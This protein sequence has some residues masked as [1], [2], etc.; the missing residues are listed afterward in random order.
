VA[1]R[2]TWAQATRTG[3]ILDVRLPLLPGHPGLV[4]NLPLADWVTVISVISDYGREG[5]PPSKVGTDRPLLRATSSALGVKPVDV[6]LLEQ[7]QLF[8]TQSAP[9]SCARELRSGRSS[10][11]RFALPHPTKRQRSS[12][13]PPLRVQCS[14]DCIPMSRGHALAVKKRPYNH[15]S[16]S[17]TRFLSCESWR[18]GLQKLTRLLFPLPQVSSSLPAPHGWQGEALLLTCTSLR[19]RQPPSLNSHSKGRLVL[20][21]TRGFAYTCWSTRRTWARSSRSSP[22]SPSSPSPSPWAP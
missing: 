1:P 3:M 11:G 20:G 6:T 14:S 5:I 16:I 15:R 22:A 13:Q 17:E 4:V 21:V 18:G 19:Q 10:A 9:K 7:D 2:D 8:M 12:P